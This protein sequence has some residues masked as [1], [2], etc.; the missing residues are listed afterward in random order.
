MLQLWLL[1]FGIFMD[2][3]KNEIEVELPQ[4]EATKANFAI[5]NA[6]KRTVFMAIA[7]IISASAP[8][9]A[10]AHPK[11]PSH[12]HHSKAYIEN[13]EREE[14]MGDKA[15]MAKLQQATVVLEILGEIDHGRQAVYEC[16][17]FIIDSSTLM[18]A[19]HCMDGD[20]QLS[21]IQKYDED[22]SHYRHVAAVKSDA[23]MIQFNQPM[24]LADNAIAVAEWGPR[25][26]EAL[27]TVGRFN[28]KE[29]A[30]RTGTF[31][32]SKGE[33]EYI[34]KNLKVRHGESGGA[35]VNKN[36]KVVGLIAESDF[37]FTARLTPVFP[38][39]ITWMRSRLPAIKPTKTNK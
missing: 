12:P 29:L 30:F 39:L 13:H 35:A 1:L 16:T 25:S 6:L 22:V 23:E 21:K 37:V 34:I 14:L 15:V 7:A 26:G 9:Q 31:V 27:M 4:N 5:P 24:F 20:K 3:L 18:T 8:G 28:S 17:G 2:H 33:K 19:H 38:A 36:G 11:K 32:R 10:E